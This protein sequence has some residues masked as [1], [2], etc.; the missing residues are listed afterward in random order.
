MEQHQLVLVLAVGCQYNQLIA[1]VGREH[2][3]YV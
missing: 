1:R 2:N 3:G